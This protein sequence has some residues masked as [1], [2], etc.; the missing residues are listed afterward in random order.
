MVIHFLVQNYMLCSYASC[1]SLNFEHLK[2]E[3]YDVEVHWFILLIFILKIPLCVRD[4]LSKIIIVYLIESLLSTINIDCLVYYDD[5]PK[6]NKEICLIKNLLPKTILV[7]HH[8][9]LSNF[10]I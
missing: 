10:S 7:K 4:F 3:H 1:F 5:Y 6:Y 2:A 9:V 8:Q